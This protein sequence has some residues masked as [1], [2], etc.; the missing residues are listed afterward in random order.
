MINNGNLTTDNAH[1]VIFVVK[2]YRL[3]LGILVVA[4]S[5]GPVFLQIWWRLVHTL[6]LVI[7]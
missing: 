5:L 7:D 6:R 4:T 3:C 1:F 2:Q